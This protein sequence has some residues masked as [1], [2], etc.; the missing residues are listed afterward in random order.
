MEEVLV[1]ID[2]GGTS[3]KLAFFDLNGEFI[4]KWEIPTNTEENGKYIVGDIADAIFAKAEEMGI[5]KN[6]LKAAG[7]GAPGFIDYKKGEVAL[8]PNLGWLNFPLREEFEHK[9][10]IPLIIEND[11]NVAAIGEMWKGAGDG[12]VNLLAVTLGT[13]VGG[14][15][16]INGHIVQGTNGMAGEIG[17]ILVEENGLLCGCGKKGC[18]E[19]IS[20]ATGIRRIAEH[21]LELNQDSKLYKVYQTQGRLEAKDVFDAAKEGDAF[22]GEIVE[23][24]MKPLAIVLTNFIHTVNPEKIVIGGGVS[25]AGWYLLDILDSYLKE[26]T[27]SRAYGAV[28]LEIAKLGNDA[29]VIGAAY[30]AKESIK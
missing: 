4:A 25:K 11:A 9:T 23:K 3:V 24:T 7:M 15:V 27:L 12:A 26:F 30:I 8:A 19:T 18:L 6:A 5:P 28:Q 21:N 17:H 16:I 1:G 22:A 13:G 2:L 14:G 10:G 29:G 20:S